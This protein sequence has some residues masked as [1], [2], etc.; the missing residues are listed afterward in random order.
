MGKKFLLHILPFFSG[1][2]VLFYGF[3]YG[4]MKK[5]KGAVVNLFTLSRDE[6]ELI[7]LFFVA[8]KK[9]FSVGAMKHNLKILPQEQA[10]NLLHR[11]RSALFCG[12]SAKIV[13]NF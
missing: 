13:R 6:N 7:L 10:T 8:I 4:L 3:T 1:A 9:N 5:W 2:F 11:K 12:S